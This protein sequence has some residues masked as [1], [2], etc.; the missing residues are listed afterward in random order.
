MSSAG[1]GHWPRSCGFL[2][3]QY[4]H[5]SGYAANCDRK[6]LA[7]AWKWGA[8]NLPGFPMLHNSFEAVERYPEERSDRY[9]PPLE[10]F[11]R[12]IDMATGQD[13][14][15]LLTFFHLGAR[16]GEVFRLT[17]ADV[18]F[19]VGVKP[20][21]FHAIRHVSAVT[22][23]K[24]GQRLSKIQ[25]NHAAPVA[26]N[27]NRALSPVPRLRPRG[28]T[29]GG[30]G[31]QR[32]RPGEDFALRP[33][34]EPPERQLQGFGISG[35]CIHRRTKR[36]GGS[37]RVESWRPQG[38]LN[39][40]YRRERGSSFPS[41]PIV[42]ITYIGTN[43]PERCFCTWPE[44]TGRVTKSER[45]SRVITPQRPFKRIV[46]KTDDTLHAHR[47]QGGGS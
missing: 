47:R 45:P 42:S 38:D 20:F 46:G 43:I 9:I 33:K 13:R 4:D 12:V 8:K 31:F 17:W 16:C 27:N 24:E 35:R 41:R 29:G 32:Q 19:K 37:N 26:V 14:V 28:T 39:P 10:D 21:G 18:D 44:V 23:A 11:M 1:A 34:R 30:G 6:N 40:C 25:K 36:L 2:D 7:A 5:R 3:H 22:L 15:M